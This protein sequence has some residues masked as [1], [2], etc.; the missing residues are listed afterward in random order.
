MIEKYPHRSADYY[1]KGLTQKHI[2]A[3]YVTKYNERD[4]RKDLSIIKEA[5][6]NLKRI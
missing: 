4:M 6:K 3:Y 1:W 2:D 5:M